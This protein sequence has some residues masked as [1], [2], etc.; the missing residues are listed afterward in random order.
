MT[1][2]ELKSELNRL[3]VQRRLGALYSVIGDSL[4]AG[5][6]AGSSFAARVA[7]R[8]GEYRRVDSFAV[9]GK[10]SDEVLSQQIPSALLSSGRM[11]I[12]TA[13]TN[14]I[15]QGIA[16]SVLRANMASIWDELID[17][18]IE[19]VDVGMMPRNAS[20]ALALNR[21][22]HELW[23]Q[24]YCA[25]NGIVHINPWPLLANPDGT[26]RSGYFYDNV[27][28]NAFS[29]DITAS[30]VAEQLD[31][32]WKCQPFLELIDRAAGAAVVMANAVGFGG[33]GSALPA[34]YFAVGTGATFS[35]EAAD[36]E[37]FGNWLRA[38]YAGSVTDSGFSGTDRTISG[39]GISVGDRI[40]V[41]VR[42]R[43]AST[44][45]SSIAP[46]IELTGITATPSTSLIFQ[47]G[48]KGANLVNDLIV[49]R[50]FTV[51]G[52]TTIGFRV[53]ANT[54]GAGYVEINRPIIYNLTTNGL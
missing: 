38:T 24:Q 35:V 23:V 18:G 44:S 27:H 6:Y 19:P 14:D 5:G 7:M 21:A 28:P 33:V 39:V 8:S 37:G 1:T 46:T 49:Y 11:C 54:G 15:E 53:K 29:A 31:A 36:A 22:N 26:W 40:A 41:G 20:A 50:E 48:G 9:G 32:P 52:G 12:I 10:R 34:G 13:G 16:P 3:K 4:A 42:V 51:T 45:A 2:V 17:A 47:E 43:W 30:D 25:K